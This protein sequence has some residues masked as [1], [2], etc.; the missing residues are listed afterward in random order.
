M[1][2]VKK[3]SYCKRE[4]CQY[5]GMV[6]KIETDLGK[7]D[8]TDE[9]SEHHYWVRLENGKLGMFKESDLE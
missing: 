4:S 9:T 8:P 5:I 1:K 2:K 3:H 6:G 7:V